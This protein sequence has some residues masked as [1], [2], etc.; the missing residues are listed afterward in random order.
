M[1]WFSQSMLKYALRKHSL[2]ADLHIH[3]L[4][5]PST[6]MDVDPALQ[7]RHLTDI[8]GSAILKG[9]DIIGIVSRNSMQPGYLAKQLIQQ[10]NYDIFCL[11]GVEIHTQ[12]GVHMVVFNSKRVPSS[13]LSIEQTCMITHRNGGIIMAIQPNRR[14]IQRLN[15][16][17][18]T[19]S[20]PDFIEIFNDVTQ[21][22]YSKSFVDTSADPDFQ[23]LMNSAARNAK[24]LDKSM[25]MTRVPRKFLVEK[26]VLQP[27]QGVGYKPPYLQ[28]PN[29]LA[30]P[31][32]QGGL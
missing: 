5:D 19:D 10:K 11:A 13:G 6:G 21:G 1:S 9:L 16:L 15:K 30:F 29:N 14:N 20:A 7:A 32:Q 2:N 24:D 3:A 8:I 4:E 22:G 26:G 27:E 31:L 18:R 25:I 23:L 12:E 28:Q 17:V